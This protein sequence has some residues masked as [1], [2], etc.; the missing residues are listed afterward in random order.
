MSAADGKPTSDPAQLKVERARMET[1]IDFFVVG[2]LAMLLHERIVTD[3]TTVRAMIGAMVG[4]A[5]VGGWM[6]GRNIG[7]GALAFVVTMLHRV[8]L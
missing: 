8:Q 5:G 3:L 7:G 2:V 4:I 6:K 1:F